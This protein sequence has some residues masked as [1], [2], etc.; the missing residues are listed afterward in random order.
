MI[1][2]ATIKDGL[3]AGLGAVLLTKKKIEESLQ[4][5]VQDDRLSE[6]EAKQLGEELMEK[7]EAQLKELNKAV[8]SAIDLGLNS[9]DIE[10]HKTFQA[11]IKKMQDLDNR[12]RQLEVS[13][14]SRKE[15]FQH[16]PDNGVIR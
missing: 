7:G 10:N 9:I 15:Q 1:I 11:L 3:A 8:L 4:T 12:V 16:Y 2:M 6:S 14:V 13:D 5:L